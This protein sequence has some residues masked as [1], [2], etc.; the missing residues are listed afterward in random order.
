MK[1][2]DGEETT[3]GSIDG[4]RSSGAL[5]EPCTE[6]FSMGGLRQDVNRRALR[7]GAAV[8]AAEIT[9]QLLRVAAT[10]V[11]ARILLPADFGLLSMVTAI[12]VFAERVKDIGLSDATVQRQRITHSEVSTLF[13]INVLVC[14]LIA[15][16]LASLS[17]L[18]ARF[19]GEPRVSGVTVVVASTFVMSGL[20]IQHQALLRRQL[21]FGMLAGIQLSAVFLSM[22]LAVILAYYGLG[23][24]ALVAREFSRAFFV[25]A[26]TWMACRWR[27]GWP[28]RGVSVSSLLSFGGNVTGFNLVYFL[29]QHVDR[30]LIGRLHGANWLG[31]Y[32]NA[33]R[34][35]VLPIQQV[36]WPVTTVS[37]PAL[38]ALQTEPDR[39]MAYYEKASRLAA[40]VISPIVI[41]SF[42]FADLVVALLLGPRWG[43][44]VPIF[45]VLAVGAMAT[46]FVALMGPALLAYGKAKVNFQIGLVNAVTR[47]ALVLLGGL[48][49]GPI[50]FALG[51][52]SAGLCSAVITLGCGMKHIPVVGRRVLAKLA[53]DVAIAALWGAILA[54]VRCV[55]GWSLNSWLLFAFALGGMAVYFA[56]WQVIPGGRQ[57]LLLYRGYL[58]RVFK[59]KK[60]GN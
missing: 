48:L 26:G 43:N 42:V 49:W 36:R 5:K 4:T 2:K 51:G 59:T 20:V 37:L 18:I 44:C 40:F 23:Y 27:P 13:W 29:S 53:V 56:V 54:G 58:G 25:M 32:D 12:S 33:H 60:P 28:R 8:M 16:V 17:T 7:G 24:W 47:V 50:G 1:A 45:R 55:A 15:G 38:S 35:L 30:I 41:F 22:V 14:V 39:F 46:P 31:F 52:S 6:F 34:L 11:L 3:D 21:Q 10:A 9:S 57:R 19:Y